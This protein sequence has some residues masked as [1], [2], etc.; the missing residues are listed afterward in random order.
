MLKA[1]TAE[2]SLVRP[3]FLVLCALRLTAPGFQG[4][5]IDSVMP[6]ANYLL[7]IDL[8]TGNVF[9]FSRAVGSHLCQVKGIV[10]DMKTFGGNNQLTIF[11]P[12][13]AGHILF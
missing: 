7:P 4:L 13:L 5:N 11:H 2:E 9:A 3:L 12:D 8:L 6:I 1:R 10:V